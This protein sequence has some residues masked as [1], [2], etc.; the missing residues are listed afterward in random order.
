[1]SKEF[2]KAILNLRGL[3]WKLAVLQS[4]K[5]DLLKF[6]FGL[7]QYKTLT[8]RLCTLLFAQQSLGV[9][10][11]SAVWIP[12]YSH[13]VSHWLSLRSCQKNNLDYKIVMRK[14]RLVRDITVTD[15]GPK[16]ARTLG[17]PECDPVIFSDSRAPS[18][19][20]KIY[21]WKRRFPQFSH[22]FV[23]ASHTNV[24][25]IPSESTIRQEKKGVV[26]T[27][28]CYLCLLVCILSTE[29]YAWYNVWV[30]Q[31]WS[32]PDEMSYNSG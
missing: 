18:S 17:P 32:F 9:F 12:L 11:K 16:V 5:L 22:R 25:Q 1:M 27:I 4:I 13:T 31:T 14:K 10:L 19:K 6:A 24:Y 23:C 28:G 29:R 8:K 3:W 26:H 2:T 20:W 15:D 7:N 30:I 21:A